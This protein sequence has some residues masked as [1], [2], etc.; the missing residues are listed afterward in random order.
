MDYVNT[1]RS[2]GFKITPQ[3]LRVIDYI[4]SRTPG[5]FRA[6]DVYAE[7]HKIEPTI[8][9]ATVYNILRTLQ[10]S[11]ILRSF[12]LKGATWFETNTQPHANFLCE[13]CGEISDIDLGESSVASSASDKG[14]AVSEC[15]Y[16]LKGTC[17]KCRNAM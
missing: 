8:T 7:V 4:M 9:M 1:L 12:E 14:Y 16:I 11:L 3:R 17:P 6:E 13:V 5:H 2:S 15:S 10:K